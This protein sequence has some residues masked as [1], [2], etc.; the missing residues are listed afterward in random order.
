MEQSTSEAK[1]A[2]RRRPGAERLLEAASDLFYREGIRAV[3]VDTISAKAGV[4]KRTLYN[5]FGGKDE[6]VGEYLRRRD[7][8]WRVHL[9]E[10]T[11]GV[12]DP[13]EKLLAVFGAYEEW[14]VGEDF[15]G[16]A[17]ANAVAEIPD[18]DH[19]AR[20]VA[21]LH[22]EGVREHLAALAKEAGFDEP[23][24]LAE[25]LLLL[26]EGAAATAAIRRSDEPLE[27]ARSVAL[28]LLEARSH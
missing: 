28:E 8:G 10:Q 11:E 6:L 7:E 9:Q 21:R 22:K 5:R 15:R 14:L 1:R 16:C 20:I 19:P 27:V 18:P 17:F 4:S 3:G 25:R 13:R 23:E 12:A 2:T 24:S 26:L